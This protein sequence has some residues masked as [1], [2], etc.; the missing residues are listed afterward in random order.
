LLKSLLNHLSSQ[1]VHTMPFPL[2][3]PLAFDGE[4]LGQVLRNIGAVPYANKNPATS[5]AAVRVSRAT[6]QKVRLS[7]LSG[8]SAWPLRFHQIRQMATG[9]SKPAASATGKGNP[10]AAR[11][12]NDTNAMAT[13]VT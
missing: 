9:A 7:Q 8:R 4:L 10:A 11:M 12:G 5:A 3:F 1:L 2:R 6:D 13:A